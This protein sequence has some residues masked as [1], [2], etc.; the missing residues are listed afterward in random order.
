MN[1]PVFDTSPTFVIEVFDVN[2]NVSPST[3]VPLVTEAKLF[4]NGD[5]SYVLVL[6][7]DRTE[8]AFLFTVRVPTSAEI[9]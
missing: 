1:V 3:R 2:S 4:V 5:P 9:L 8:I 7:P 6:E